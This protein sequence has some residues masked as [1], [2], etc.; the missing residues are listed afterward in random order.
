MRGR[1]NALENWVRLGG[2]EENEDKLKNA[3][4]L[5]IVACGTSWHSGLIA[6]YIFEDLARNSSRSRI[7]F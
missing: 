6:E 7:C 1:L 3:E 2:I 5:I 4:R